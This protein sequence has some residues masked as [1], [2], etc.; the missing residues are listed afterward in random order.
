MRQESLPIF[1]KKSLIRFVHHKARDSSYH[2]F[3]REEFF[4]SVSSQ[5]FA[6]VQRFELKFSLPSRGTGRHDMFEL[7]ANVATGQFH[8]QCIYAY[9]S[10]EEVEQSKACVTEEMQGLAN[11]IMAREGPHKLRKND[12]TSLNQIIDRIMEEL[13]E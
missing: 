5:D 4:K 6:F 11:A 10:A 8:V 2:G 1:Y 3:K 7:R 13:R 9:N 12:L